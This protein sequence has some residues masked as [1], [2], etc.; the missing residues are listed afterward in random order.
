MPKNNNAI[1]DSWP[2]LKDDLVL[3]LSDTDAWTITRLKEAHTA[4]DWTR[5][6]RII[7]VMDLLHDVSHSH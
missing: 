1:L 6:K 7:D 3:F 4:K 2:E 5:V